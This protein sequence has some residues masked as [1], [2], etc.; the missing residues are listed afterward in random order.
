MGDQQG[1]TWTLQGVFLL[2]G[3][4]FRGLFCTVPSCKVP[5]FLGAFSQGAF[6]QGAL[7][8][9]LRGKFLQSDFL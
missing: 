7:V 9:L 5:F 3:T 6:L 4:F 2:L 1:W 8:A